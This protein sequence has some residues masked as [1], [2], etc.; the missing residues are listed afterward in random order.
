MTY[1]APNP[2][3]PRNGHRHAVLKTARV[4]LAASVALTMA[5]PSASAQYMSRGP[6]INVNVGPRVTPNINPTISVGPRVTP[7]INPNIRP[8]MPN[9][10]YSPNVTYEEPD[11]VP[12]RRRIKKPPTDG[13]GG[14]PKTA[15][16]SPRGVADAVNS[17][18][19][20]KEIILEITGNP[21]DAQIEALARR[22][23]LTRVESQDFPLI[24]SRMFRWRI[25]DNRSVETVI[26]Q[27]MSGGGVQSAHPNRR[28]ALQ[29]ANQPEQYAVTKLR[30]VEAHT[31]ARGADVMI[32]VIDS[33]IDAT[34]P[35][36][37]GVIAGSYDPLGG[38]AMSHAHGT[39]I[40]GA[41]AAHDRLM[42]AAPSARILAIRAFGNATSGAESTSFIILK[43]LE[44]AATRG[45]KIV[46]MSFAG[47]RDALIERSLAALNER[48]IILVAASGNA[49]PK[50]PPLYPAAD[51]HVI[52]VSATDASDKLFPASNRG[53]HIA[54]AAPGA[55]VLLPSADGKY[56]VTSG[57]SF[58]AAYVSGLAALMLE[59][60]P[61]L[62]PSD[63][64]DVLIRTAQDLG[65]P[66][67]DDQ[68]GAGKA[69]AFGAVAAASATLAT[70][71]DRPG[72]ATKT[73]QPATR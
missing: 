47:P 22:H 19:V 26:R 17:R 56:Q 18:Y 27:V 16:A 38:P 59:R 68:F 33:G 49:G 2:A 9:V 42:G 40:A 43:S 55:D 8:V 52:A 24:G 44:F 57:T 66:G 12:P 6:N 65:P 25:N 63:V 32:A 53:S 14:S 39:G 20:P 34:H 5:M 51:K 70:A 31:I 54:V 61:A 60:N 29:Q 23:R 37:A 71:A 62:K 1:E 36:L 4:L 7:N 46:N 64:K 41:I 30:L 73:D 67:R 48:G 21:T 3:V 69:D 50:S 13:G 58:A 72:S 35:E 11:D 15:N 28:F 10:R 45:A